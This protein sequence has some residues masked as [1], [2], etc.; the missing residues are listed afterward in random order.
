[1]EGCYLV[2]EPGMGEF[3]A[4]AGHP[5]NFEFAVIY[6]KDEIR[7]LCLCGKM[8]PNLKREL[9]WVYHMLGKHSCTEPQAQSLSFVFWA[10]CQFISDADVHEELDFA[11]CRFPDCGFINTLSVTF[12][13]L[14]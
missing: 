7:F 1:R 4:W 9:G 5:S 2:R 14:I 13:C 8:A 11:D 12:L 6:S 3:K 10:L